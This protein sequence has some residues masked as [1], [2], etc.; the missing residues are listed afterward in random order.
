[1]LS[2]NT[3]FYLLRA[4]ASSYESDFIN[5]FGINSFEYDIS[6]LQNILSYYG[7]KAY[8]SSSIKI[9]KILEFISE[10]VTYQ[11]EMDDIFRF[12][13]ET[14]SLGSGDCDDYSILVATLFECV[15]ID[16]AL[17]YFET[18]N[19]DHVLVLVHLDELAISNPYYEQ[20]YYLYDDLTHYGL[21]SGQWIM[22]EPQSP[23]EYQGDSEWFEQMDIQ[24]AVE[25]TF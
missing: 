14:L 25:I 2:T 15:G 12:P 8:D 21:Q 20:R 11:L 4:R 13:L 22:I 9:E 23:I 7:V 16:S 24:Q 18:N 10:V 17:A 19:G 5:E 3:D 6:H 1:M